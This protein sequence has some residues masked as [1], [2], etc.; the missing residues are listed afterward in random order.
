MIVSEHE[1]YDTVFVYL[2]ARVLWR[3]DSW[4]ISGSGL[5]WRRRRILLLSPGTGLFSNRIRAL[6][7][8]T[9]HAL[10]RCLLPS[11]AL[12][13]NHKNV[14]Y[15][16]PATTPPMLST[17]SS[18]ALSSPCQ[19]EIV[20]QSRERVSS[21][22]SAPEACAV[23]AGDAQID[24]GDARRPSRRHSL[25]DV[26]EDGRCSWSPSGCD[27][28]HGS[29]LDHLSTMDSTSL[30]P[31]SQ[32]LLGSWLLASLEG[33]EMKTASQTGDSDSLLLVDNFCEEIGFPTPASRWW[34]RNSSDSHFR[35]LVP[36][37]LPK[38]PVQGKLS[39]ATMA[40]RPGDGW[41]TSW[42]NSSSSV[43]ISQDLEATTLARRGCSRAAPLFQQVPSGSQSRAADHGDQSRTALQARPV[44]PPTAPVP[45]NQEQQRE[46]PTQQVETAN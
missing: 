16:G 34:D 7:Q 25:S 18:A 27:Q 32:Q 21:S 28:E 36:Q 45:T 40:A 11:S 31:A 43:H 41:A 13:P 4:A 42:G 2:N 30:L 19:A 6:F 26:F 22:A 44:Q 8:A 24:G 23:V 46:I 39:Y 9:I 10:C 3:G 35:W 20:F 37:S 33:E 29:G 14:S 15:I 38:K 5:R 12:H 17:S 1:K